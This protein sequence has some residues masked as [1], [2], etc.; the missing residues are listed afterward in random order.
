[1]AANKEVFLDIPLLISL[2]GRKEF[3]STFPVFMQINAAKAKLKSGKVTGCVPCG[4]K[5]TPD[6]A[7]FHDAIHQVK[8]FLATMSPD[9]K[10]KFK[11][12]L[13]TDHVTLMLPDSR[14]RSVRTIRF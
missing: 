4:K 1:M 8:S 13:N 7:A 11:Q 9:L 10:Q 3:L 2:A 12:L 5:P 14:N 6:Q